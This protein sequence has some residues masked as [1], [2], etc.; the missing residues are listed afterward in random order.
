VRRT[1]GTAAAV[2]WLMIGVLVAA[3]HGFFGHTSDLGQVSSAVLAV[4]AWPYVAT[5]THLAI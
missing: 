4:A 3:S 2:A 5:N 1:F